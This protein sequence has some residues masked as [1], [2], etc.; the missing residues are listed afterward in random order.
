MNNFDNYIPSTK[1]K[2]YSS[3]FNVIFRDPQNYEFVY[4]YPPAKC[5][6]AIEPENIF[7]TTNH[8]LLKV[9]RPFLYFHLPFCTGKCTYCHYTRWTCFKSNLSL[10]EDYLSA[11]RNEVKLLKRLILFDNNI[12]DVMH[13]GGGT[14]TFLNQDQIKSFMD[15]IYSQFIVS[16]NREITWES[17]PETILLNNGSKLSALLE[18]GVNRLNIGIQSFDDSLLRIMGRRHRAI[19]SIKAIH[20]A[21]EKGF[22]NINID[23]IYGLPDQTINQWINTLDIVGTLLPESVTIY[24]LR[25]K[26]GTPMSRIEWSRFP[27][28]KICYEMGN[29]MIDKLEEFGYISWQP[30]QFVLNSNYS[31]R[32]LKSKWERQ[33]EIVGFGV[34]AY[35]YINDF[36]YINHR[37]LNDYY[38]HIKSGRLPI[39][40]GKKLTIEQKIA[41]T[42]VL[43]IKILPQGLDKKKFFDL[44]GLTL[45]DIY[46]SIISNLEEIGVIDS[47]ADYLRLTRKGLLFA[48]EICTEF[49]TNSDKNTL[50]QLGATI[51]GSYL[52]PC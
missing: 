3:N 2:T 13:F 50:K 18:S 48:D 20:T 14:P 1:N 37:Y 16:G 26:P 28:K 47:T 36:M 23:L 41:K 40:I 46:G 5:L 38:E 29:L 49:Y 10:V 22:K 33:T 27:S 21:R 43:G 24:Q 45:E 32:Y 44:Y 35:S 30:N 15:F 52:D 42:V 6:E 9:F 11:L 19:D 31:H 8:Q 4:F 7:N 51:Y 17:S 12:I 39:F 25:I 34:S